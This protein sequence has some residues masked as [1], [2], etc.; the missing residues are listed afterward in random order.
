MGTALA[1]AIAATPTADGT[2]AGLFKALTSRLGGDAEPLEEPAVQRLVER[3][4][5]GDRDAAQR[6]YRQQ[7]D[8]VFRTV[9][10]VLRSDAEAED[11]TQDAMLA[12]LTSLDRYTPREDARFAAWV[13]SVAVN[14]ARRR[15]RRRRPELTA[16]GELP[17]V[18][19]ES[20]PPERE[21]DTA[22]EREALLRALADL[23]PAEREMISLRYGAEL[24]ASEIAKLVKLEPANVRKILERTRER[25]GARIEELLQ[26][27]G[28][29]L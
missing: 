15:F 18:P 27:T 13:A 9:R 3:A 17:D 20:A 23:A 10:G 29:N 1:L 26:R 8:R 7:V 14:T 6:L 22:R 16:T 11:V 4:R 2:L 25:L 24:T 19:D 12:V 5:A 28:T 21:V